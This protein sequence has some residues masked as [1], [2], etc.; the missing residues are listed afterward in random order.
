[1][2]RPALELRDVRGVDLGQLEYR[3]APLVPE[4]TAFCARVL[5]VCARATAMAPAM[6]T[7]ATTAIVFFM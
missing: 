4:A 3:V 7:M 5:A 2:K 6:A 1:M